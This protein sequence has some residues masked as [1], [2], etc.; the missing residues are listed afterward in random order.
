M[1]Y[2]GDKPLTDY[3]INSASLEGVTESPLTIE[4]QI[5]HL[6]TKRGVRLLEIVIVNSKSSN[7]PVLSQINGETKQ[8][9]EL[10]FN[11]FLEIV[12]HNA[13]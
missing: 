5:I 6:L 10:P 3:W 1:H 11:T 12:Q 8:L 13:F 2:E 9:S 7:E 4:D